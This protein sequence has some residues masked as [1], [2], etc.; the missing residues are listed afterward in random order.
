MIMSQSLQMRRTKCIVRP[1]FVFEQVS[2]IEVAYYFPWILLDLL[3]EQIPS[4]WISSH[5]A[6]SARKASAQHVQQSTE[7][8]TK[9]FRGPSS[10]LFFKEL[11]FLAIVSATFLL[12]SPHRCF[13]DIS[14]P[15][16]LIPYRLQ[17]LP[18]LS[19]SIG[20]FEYLDK[21][22]VFFSFLYFRN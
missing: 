18:H 21:N 4:R 11:Q 1:E 14:Q 2:L 7:H 19:S 8:A 13:R 9:I 20:R 16:Y 22:A 15:T 3:C 12:S 17:Y 5:L 6:W 10:P